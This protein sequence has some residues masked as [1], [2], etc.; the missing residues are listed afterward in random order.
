[1]I[2]VQYFFKCYFFELIFVTYFFPECFPL[3]FQ[4]WSYPRWLL[5]FFALIWSVFIDANAFLWVWLKIV[6]GTYT[7]W[8]CGF[9]SPVGLNKVAVSVQVGCNSLLNS[10]YCFVLSKIPFNLIYQDFLCWLLTFAFSIYF[11]SIHRYWNLSLGV[12]ENFLWAVYNFRYVDLL[13]LQD[14]GSFWRGYWFCDCNFHYQFIEW[15][16]DNHLKRVGP[17][18]TKDHWDHT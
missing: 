11:I 7:N 14:C 3:N 15:L 13:P 6:C 1:M 12:I 5:M 9:A 4:F 16:Q 17:I 10:I 8:T 2:K 18:G